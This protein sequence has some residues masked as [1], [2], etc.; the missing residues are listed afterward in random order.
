[1][2]AAELNAVQ[3]A[4]R[5]LSKQ[6]TDLEARVRVAE[7]KAIDHAVRA[8]EAELRAESAAESAATKIGRDA[9]R[10]R[11]A[12]MKYEAVQRDLETARAY[13]TGKVN[14]GNDT[15]SSHETTSGEVRTL[16]HSMQQKDLSS[17]GRPLILF[18]I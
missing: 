12:E 8:R 2:A 11:E 4:V 17:V 16:C 14:A 9:V 1:M 6:K 10:A 13:Q 15:A 5:A 7:Q 3:E 18:C